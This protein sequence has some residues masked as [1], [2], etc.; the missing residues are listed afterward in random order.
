MKNKTQV[1][2]DLAEYDRMRAAAENLLSRG[3]SMAPLA[4]KICDTGESCCRSYLSLYKYID[5][6][7]DEFGSPAIKKRYEQEIKPLE[8]SKDSLIRLLDEQCQDFFRA[9]KVEVPNA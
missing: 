5:D 9:A 1:L 6:H 8:E 7:P 2:K 4:I 3:H